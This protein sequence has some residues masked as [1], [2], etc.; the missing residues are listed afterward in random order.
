VKR[1]AINRSD[2][3]VIREW[4]QR[5]RQ[6]L[7]RQS[8]KAKRAGQAKPPIRNAV[9]ER[10]G[11]RCVL[12]G[13]AGTGG[14]PECWGRLTPHHLKKAGQGGAYSTENLVTLCVRH[15]DDVEDQPNL[16]RAL[17]LVL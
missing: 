3:E 8:V 15:N 11:Y 10:D 13:I 9:F 12:A 17:G 4:Q 1:S 7:P 5:S 6:R 2:P 16:Y 14:L